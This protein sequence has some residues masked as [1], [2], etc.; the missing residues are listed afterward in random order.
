VTDDTIIHITLSSANPD[1]EVRSR[2]RVH[3][4]FQLTFC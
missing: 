1:T 2:E 4:A 3:S